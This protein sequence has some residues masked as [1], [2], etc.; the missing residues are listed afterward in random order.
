[1]KNRDWMGLP[2]SKLQLQ[3]TIS[4]LESEDSGI[5]Q[6]MCMTNIGKGVHFG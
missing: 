2:A 3:T 5:V 1:M 6:Y 4:E